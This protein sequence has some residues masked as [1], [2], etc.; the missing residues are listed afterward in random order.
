MFVRDQHHPASNSECTVAPRKSETRHNTATSGARTFDVVGQSESALGDSGF[1]SDGIHGKQTMEPRHRPDCAP[2]HFATS[3]ARA[4]S[5][6]HGGCCRQAFRQC[7]SVPSH[8]QSH[9]RLNIKYP[10]AGPKLLIRHSERVPPD[11]IWTVKIGVETSGSRSGTASDA[12]GKRKR[13]ISRE[14]NL[15][16]TLRAR[17]K[18]RWRRT[19]GCGL[20]R[21]VDP[22]EGPANLGGLSLTPAARWVCAPLR[23]TQ[24]TGH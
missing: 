10:G 16:S 23:D 5:R 14:G 12:S 15:H 6:P 17:R 11:R 19:D 2:C 22:A 7:H 24:R 18:R 3:H 8:L 13:A 4:W 20:P 21:F 9:G 1:C